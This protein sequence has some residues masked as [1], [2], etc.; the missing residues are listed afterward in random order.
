MW[1]QFVKD[2]FSFTKKERRVVVMLLI[3]IAILFLLP[4]VWPSLEEAPSAE[5]LAEFKQAVAQLKSATAVDSNGIDKINPT[6]NTSKNEKAITGMGELFYFDPNTLSQEGW[7]RLGLSDRTIHTIQH[8]L[9]KGGQFK[10]PADL[11]KIYGL[12]PSDAERLLP[13]V[14]VAKANAYKKTG[15]DEYAAPKHSYGDNKKA[16]LSLDINVADTSAFI[17]LPGIGSKLASRIIHFRDKLGGFYSIEQVAETYGL[18]DSTFQK[19]KPL[20]RCAGPVIHQLNINTATA[21][22]L[23]QHPY[24]G[25][26]ANVI[27]QYRTQHGAFK[28]LEDLLKMDVM[29]GER[30]ERVR[31]YLLVE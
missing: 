13:Y 20:L 10:K 9:S 15:G 28:A 29:T 4:Y 8:Y 25:R 18:P 1:K 3:I 30:L 27:V 19:I 21:A 23:Q 6:D 24:I 16:L 5:K 12:K 26:L 31:P 17:S 7:K 2:Y 11:A 14:Q 22:D